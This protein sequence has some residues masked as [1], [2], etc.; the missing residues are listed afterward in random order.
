MDKQ[1]WVPGD[2]FGLVIPA[3]AGA[4]KSAG[5]AFLDSAFHRFGALSPDNHVTAITQFQECPGGSTGRKLL[6]SLRYARPEAQL[7][8][9]LFVKF[10]RDFDDPR[11]DRGR[12]QMAREVRFAVLTRGDFPIP[13]PTAAFADYH[14]ASGTGVLITERIP[15]GVAPVEP[16]YDKCLDYRLPDP[17]AHYE[18]LLS[19]VARLA[20]AQRAGRLAP[21]FAA[22]FEFDPD[23]VTVGKP[24]VYSPDQLRDRVAN[25]GAFAAAHPALLPARLRSTEFVDRMQREV[26]GIAA[27]ADAVQDDLNSTK[28]YVALCHWNANVDNAWFWRT[29]GRLHCGL[30]DWGCVSQMNVAMALWGALCSA[31]TSMWEAHLEHLLAH[32]ATEFEAAGGPRLDPAEIRRQLTAYALVMGVTWLLDAPAYLRALVPE[33][34]AVADRHDPRIADNE[35]ARSQLLMLTNF[36]HLWQS[37]D[38]AEIHR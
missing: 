23:L 7:P 5:V 12:T 6:L 24:P 15:Y 36:L 34:A 25:Y 8:E 19:T 11:R 2:A 20:G 10:S 18:A 14:E 30:L 21:G 32:F 13:V 33:L 28:D 1:R 38:F 31:E 16:H 35:A 26:T 17:L 9:D 27:A 37:R 4:L 3:D 22:G 29:A